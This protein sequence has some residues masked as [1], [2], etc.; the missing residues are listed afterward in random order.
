[1]YKPIMKEKES[2]ILLIFIFH[3]LYKGK[4][5]GFLALH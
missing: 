3:S 2:H 4:S 1:M 5:L